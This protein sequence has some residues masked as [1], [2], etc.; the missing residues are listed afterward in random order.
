M[1][2][3]KNLQYTHENVQTRDDIQAR[4]HIY[5]DSN[6]FITSHWHNSMEIVYIYA[7]SMEV[8]VNTKTTI[9]NEGDFIIINS[10]DI[11]STMCS[12]KCKIMLLQISYSF[13][14]KSIP[15][16][17]HIRFEQTK[18]S[19]VEGEV[20]KLLLSM[21]ESFHANEAGFSLHFSALLYEL[22]YVL[23]KEYRYEIPNSVKIKTDKN[24]NRLKSVIEYVK[25]NY[26][27]PISLEEVAGVAAF[28][29][30][31]FCRFFKKYTGLTFLDY[32]AGVRLTHI[33]QDLISTDLTISDIL[34]K[35]GFTN[36][37]LFMKKFKETYGDTPLAVRKK[38][39]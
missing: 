36:Y 33:Y 39:K 10:A 13:L 1:R 4:F 37:K 16:Y 35:N 15:D 26:A 30:E 24:T 27:S 22:L 12:D 14:H 28:N 7:G 3:N 23:F 6:D 5:E 38:A 21:G 2:E 11:H 17:E 25:C 31:Y 20:Q 29:P 19:E 18:N 8:V 9:L 32:L 34:D